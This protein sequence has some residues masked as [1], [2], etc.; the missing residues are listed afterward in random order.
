MPTTL[1]SLIARREG[2]PP[3]HLRVETRPLRGG[4]EAASIDR[5]TARYRDARNRERVVHLVVKRLAGPA[6][7][8]ATIYEELVAKQAADLAPRILH[9]QHLGVERADVYME[10]LRP[11]RAW[12]WRER[13]AVECV[14]ECVASLH[15][16]TVGAEAMATLRDWDYEVELQSTA[17]LTLE[18]L[19]RL[20][21]RTAGWRVADALRWTRRVVDVLP[22]LRRELLAHRAF[23]RAIIHG[24][25]HSGNVV[26]RRRRGRLEPLLLDWGRARVG[27]PLEDV[28]SW[29]QSL[30]AWEPEARR[31]HD[32]LFVG[33]L[34]ACG[35]EPRLD[36]G[37][38]A[39]YWLA[40]ASNA[41]A[42]ALLY[43]LAV[44]LD[45][46]VSVARRASAAWMAREW[47]RVL[48]R[49]DY[50]WS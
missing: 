37:A 41:L 44:L 34:A 25:L 4:L 28:S 6:I 29:L 45:D 19:E 40:G 46:R 48:R 49:A 18:R 38:R 8:E 11:V 15:A 47:V 17:I 26:L 31:R 42:G 24:D 2:V 50:F 21:R 9:V 30:G 23:G 16:R 1:E 20:D 32:T 10:A 36:A 27:S 43:H 12:P 7:R 3:A 35:M 13:R 39:A 33:Y 22:T 5:I 14:L